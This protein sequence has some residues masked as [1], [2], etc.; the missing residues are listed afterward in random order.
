MTVNDGAAGGLEGVKG[1]SGRSNESS[2]YMNAT[3]NSCIARKGIK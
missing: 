2:F 3:N 1:V